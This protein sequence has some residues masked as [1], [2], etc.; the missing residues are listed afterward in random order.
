[1]HLCSQIH[2]HLW[3]FPGRVGHLAHI[4]HDIQGFCRLS[5]KAMAITF[6]STFASS[7]MSF[8]ILSSKT[9]PVQ[10]AMLIS[11]KK[12]MQVIV[13]LSKRDSRQMGP[14]SGGGN[15]RKDISKRWPWLLVQI[16]GMWGREEARDFES[17][18]NVCSLRRCTKV[19]FEM[20]A[21]LFSLFLA[22]SLPC[23]GGSHIPSACL[24]GGDHLGCQPVDKCSTGPASR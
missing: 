17:G 13:H 19:G 2:P 18:S 8:S 24:G 20:L 5:W 14:G 15:E 6:W 7:C 21:Q 10:L 9:G 16:A 4:P 23:K 12:E 3:S 1:M 22:L 11:Y